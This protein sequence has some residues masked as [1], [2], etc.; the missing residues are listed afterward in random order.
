MSLI[1]LFKFFILICVF[2]LMGC[3][4]EKHFLKSHIFWYF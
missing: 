2:H 1:E 4:N 3:F